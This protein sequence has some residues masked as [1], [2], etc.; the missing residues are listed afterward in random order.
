MKSID[1]NLVFSKYLYHEIINILLKFEFE[2]Y[3]V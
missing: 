3:G 1:A 2:L